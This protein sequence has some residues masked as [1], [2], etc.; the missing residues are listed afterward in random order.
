MVTPDREKQLADAEEI[1]GE[2]LEQRG[3]VKGLF[4]GQYLA[5]GLLPYPKAMG[6]PT[7]S[8]L[9]QRLREFCASQI[10]PVAID[11]QAEIPPAVVTGLGKLG[12]LGACLPKECGGLALSQ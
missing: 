5:E 6:E 9:P 7:A 3:F 8:D 11:R 12:I 2:R 4:F 1:L 10:D